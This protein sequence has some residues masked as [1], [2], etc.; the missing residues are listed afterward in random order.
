MYNLKVKTSKWLENLNIDRQ[1]QR[2]VLTAVIFGAI[3]FVFVVWE[4]Q[5]RRDFGPSGVAA[6]VD[7]R[8][9]SSADVIAAT[10][11]M[12]GDR[13]QD[14]SESGRRK[15]TQQ[16]LQAL[17][18]QEILYKNGTTEGF[19]VANQAVADIIIKAPV[20]VENGVF[21]RE[22]YKAFLE[23]RHKTANELEE[24]LR[25]GEV[26]RKV[27]RFFATVLQP[28]P[29]EVTVQLDLKKIKANLE[30][31]KLDVDKMVAESQIS[32]SDASVYLKGADSASRI[33]SYYDTHREE[34][35]TGEKVKAR[36]ILFATKEGD[37]ASEKAALTKANE[38]LAQLKNKGDFAKLA[39]QHSD[40]PGSKNNGGELGFFERG[41][42]VP[43]FEKAAFAAKPMEVSG[44]VKTKFGIH[45]IQVLDKV[46]AK[47]IDAKGAEATIAKKL[48]AKERSQKVYAE[49][50][51]A[52]KAGDLKAIETHLEKQKVKWEETG[53]FSIDSEYIPKVGANEELAK[54]GFQL[55]AQNPIY[56]GVVREGAMAYVLKYKPVTE[57]KSEKN[58][59]DILAGLD[60][61]NPEMVKLYLANQVMQETFGR[62]QKSLIAKAKIKVGSQ[63]SGE[64]GASEGPGDF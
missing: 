42:M 46:A 14:Q 16:A 27:Q 15:L 59:K 25:K 31:A 18:Q 60:F 53:A 45:L 22:R 58:K 28:N 11:N 8:V 9:I 43:E 64:S 26:E 13:R 55:S 7:G 61:D 35:N 62:W 39:K 2:R 4:I 33:K 37:M 38:V 40:D 52:A 50:E 5:P 24:E 54:I 17:I 57:A 10:E 51:S 36:H 47:S 21:K 48:I 19:G 44:P 32:D 1:L 3:V 56:K 29:L 41:S 30:F 34:F 49:L 23:A 6:Q 63:F 12:A 20:F